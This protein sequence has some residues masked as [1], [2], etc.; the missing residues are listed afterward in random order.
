[1][2]YI[3]EKTN[4]CNQCCLDG[5]KFAYFLAIGLNYFQENN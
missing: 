3:R 5:L 4:F 2:R 1:M